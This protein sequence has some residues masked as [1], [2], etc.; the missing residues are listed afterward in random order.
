MHLIRGSLAISIA[1]SLVFGQ[2]AQLRAAE[3]G[4]KI[5]EKVE[6]LG[7]GADV[8]VYGGQETPLRGTIE[9]FDDST[10]RLMRGET[11]KLFRYDEVNV[12]ELSQK[13]YLAERGPDP[14]A[15]PRVLQT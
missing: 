1:V 14:E 12:L 9:S 6:S 7:P 3:P 15:A 2:A 4:Q 11:S 8:R 13:S 5:R 10:F